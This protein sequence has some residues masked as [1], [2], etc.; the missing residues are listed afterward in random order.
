MIVPGPGYKAIPV[1]FIFSILF[2]SYTQTDLI[3]ELKNPYNL[4]RISDES[5]G[6]SNQSGTQAALTDNLGVKEL[7]HGLS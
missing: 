4:N 3:Q 7:H 5:D 2:F 1:G 6:N